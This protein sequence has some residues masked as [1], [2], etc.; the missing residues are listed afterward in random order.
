LDWIGWAVPDHL[1]PSALE[2][3]GLSSTLVGLVGP[4]SVMPEPA[5]V[6]AVGREVGAVASVAVETG[7]SGEPANGTMLVLVIAAVVAGIVA[8]GVT[9]A[10]AAADSVPDLATLSAVGASQRVRRR[11]AAAQA[12]VIAGL[13][14]W[15]GV[16]TGLALGW[17]LVTMQATAYRDWT[18]QTIIP[19]ATVGAILVLV[20]VA[21]MAL[22]WST[23]RSRLPAVRRAAW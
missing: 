7:R 11:F 10:L 2:P 4:T 22:G 6:R 3:L 20:P 15:I 5:E 8:T 1:P 13:G 9:I 17:A 12:V 21:A 23:T 16:P 14:G 19:W 18:W